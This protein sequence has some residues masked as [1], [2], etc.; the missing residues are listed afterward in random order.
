M[1]SKIRSNDGYQPRKSTVF[2]LII[3]LKLC[4]ADAEELLACAGYSL[5]HSIKQ[6]VVMEFVIKQEIYDINIVNEILY[7]LKCQTLGNKE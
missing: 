5:S 1:F 4:L 7:S 6:D 2:A 3:G